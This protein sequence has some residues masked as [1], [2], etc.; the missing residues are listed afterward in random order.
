MEVFDDVSK[1]WYSVAD[2]REERAAHQ[3][4]QYTNDGMFVLIHAMFG[5]KF[6]TLQKKL[7]YFPK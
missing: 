4:V 6:P 1:R 2:M 3:M 5:E 7:Y